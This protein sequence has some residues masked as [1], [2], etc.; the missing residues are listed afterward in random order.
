MQDFYYN[1]SRFGKMHGENI[2]VL[3]KIGLRECTS[4]Y[5]QQKTAILNDMGNV[6]W[7]MERGISLK[8]NFVNAH[9]SYRNPS[10]LFVLDYKRVCQ[11]NSNPNY[12]Y[13]L[14]FRQSFCHQHS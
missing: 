5:N 11:P 6:F 9:V 14:C 8:V 3:K 2:A 7:W 1:K 10:W 4:D 12:M 13:Y